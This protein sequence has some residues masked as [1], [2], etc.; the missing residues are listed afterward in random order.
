M[1]ILSDREEFRLYPIP[2]LTSTPSSSTSVHRLASYD[3]DDPRPYTDRP[4]D[5]IWNFVC[6]HHHPGSR[7]SAVSHGMGS[8]VLWRFMTVL[9]PAHQD[10]TDETTRFGYSLPISYGRNRAIWSSSIR[11]GSINLMS[12]PWSRNSAQPDDHCGYMRLGI[13][14]AV[15]GAP[16]ISRITI[17]GHEGAAVND[18]S[19]SEED[20]LIC[21]VFKL[22]EHERRLIVVCLT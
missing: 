12:C 17:T 20:G 8:A 18:L 16:S 22:S 3:S 2:S 15:G 10:D 4:H 1:I 14:V 13:H 21:M 7:L 11:D 6:E 9:P 5:K 19:Y